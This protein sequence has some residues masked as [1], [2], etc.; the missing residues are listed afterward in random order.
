[1]ITQTHSGEE[2]TMPVQIA[3]DG[4]T[5]HGD[6]QVPSPALGLVIFVHGSGSSRF[7]P[8]N[9]YVARELNK[10]GLAT[11]LLDLLTQEEQAIDDQTMQLRFDI[12]L[13]GS[14]ATQVANWVLRQ[15]ELAHLPIGLFGA[16]TGA[17]AAL[18]TAAVMPDRIAAVVSRG[19]RADLAESALDVVK[20]PT[21]LVVGGEDDVVLDLNRKAM[22]RMHCPTELHV[23]PGATHLFEEI[24][25]LEDVAQVGADWF[26]RYM[27]VA[28]PAAK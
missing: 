4:S 12:S 1:M 8:R 15:P 2:L 17:A 3:L 24:G 5:L 18:I 23:V 14:R 22:K 6:L 10:H 25:A 27:Q 11:L 16:S 7:S 19:G 20:A 28:A 13:L 9:R 26:V 21:L